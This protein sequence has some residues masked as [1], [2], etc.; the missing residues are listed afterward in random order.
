MTASKRETAEDFFYRVF[1]NLFAGSDSVLLHRP[2]S[3]R[4]RGIAVSRNS[5]ARCYGQH[6]RI[7]IDVRLYLVAP[8]G[9]NRANDIRN[10]TQ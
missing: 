7:I 6:L 1:R 8:Y 2:E 10:N 9:I 5:F 3:L 4:R